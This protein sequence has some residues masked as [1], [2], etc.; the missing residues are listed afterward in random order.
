MPSLPNAPPGRDR[1]IDAIVEFLAGQDLLTLRDVR[2]ALEEEIDRAGPDAVVALKAR[3]TADHGW[4]YYPP[5]PLARRVHHRLADR[6]LTLDSELVG[7]NRVATVLGAPVVVVANHVSYADANVI[8]VLLQRSGGA[9][10]A[11]R[12]TA[13]AG[14][15]V[16]TSRERRFSSLCFGTI[17]VP[18]SNEVSTEEAV[19]SSRDVARAARRAIEVAHARLVAGDALLLFGEGTRSRTGAMQPMLPGVARYLDLPGTWIL[20]IGLAG[21]ETLFAVEDSTLRPARVRMHVGEAIRADDL[22]HSARGD[23]RAVMDAIGHAI[24]QLV[25]LPYRGVYAVARDHGPGI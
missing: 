24:A 18:Q 14:P 13:L 1:L 3:L 17:K 2:T 9:A 20:P 12:L 11:G 23:R 15:K 4:D 21:T 19:L 7:A 10:L 25:P 16:F 6:F 5:D 8:E 22:L